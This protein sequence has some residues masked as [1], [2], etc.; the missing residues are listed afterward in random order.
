MAFGLGGYPFEMCMIVFGVAKC[1]SRLI[2]HY[3]RL[4][5]GSIKKLFIQLRIELIAIVSKYSL[6]F[7]QSR[8]RFMARKIKVSAVILN[9]RLH[10][11]SPEI[12]QNY[13]R[14]IYKLKLPVN[15]YGDRYAMI[16]SIDLSS[17]NSDD[18][19]GVITSFTRLDNEGTWFDAANLQEATDNQ[20][21]RITIPANIFPNSASFYFKFNATT[22]KIF[23]QQYSKGKSFTTKS[24]LKYFI[25]VA[26]NLSILEK[27]G[28][29]KISV[30]QS[31]TSLDNLFSLK[32]LSE[33]KITLLKPNSDI[34][35]ED[36]ESKI[37][38]HLADSH[39]QKLVLNYDADHG[40]SIVPS[41]E[42]IAIGNV[43]LENGKV[44]V[45]GRDETGA[46][47]KSTENYPKILQDKYDP[48]AISENE[49]FKRLANG[50]G[51]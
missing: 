18:I 25:K 48:E 24:M 46:V 20:I 27:Y 11:H 51:Y 13:V 6:F 14:D 29:A 1:I 12:Y 3:C 19:S 34:F 50:E 41:A 16:S 47:A 35:S 4:I 39:S 22:H 42:M 32:K 31:K 37:E 43:A 36:F 21:S 9:I 5:G 26:E 44:E 10:P 8:G 45:K 40:K 28:A 2:F 7:C 23:I 15:V 38:A 17:V 33:V 30:V 49:A